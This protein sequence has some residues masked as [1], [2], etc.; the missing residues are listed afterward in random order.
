MAQTSVSG[1]RER[2]VRDSTKAVTAD[3]ALCRQI[4]CVL[5]TDEQP[6]IRA[7]KGEPLLECMG[8]LVWALDHDHEPGFDAARVLPAWA[9][10]RSRG[11]WRPA[12]AAERTW[13]GNSAAEDAEIAEA[14]ENGGRSTLPRS[15]WGIRFSPEQ[16]EE[17]LRRMCG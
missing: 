11:A 7:F 14:V 12:R 2:V 10:K 13:Y 9:K 17:N 3:R 1:E 5:F 6:I 8:M 15:G 16:V 4:A